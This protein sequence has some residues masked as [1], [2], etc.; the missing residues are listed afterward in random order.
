MWYRVVNCVQNIRKRSHS[1]QNIS[2]WAVLCTNGRREVRLNIQSCIYIPLVVAAI[3][4]F[5]YKYLL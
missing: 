1:C 5:N 4:W 2:H 3:I